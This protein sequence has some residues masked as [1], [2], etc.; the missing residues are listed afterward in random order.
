[1]QL[2]KFDCDSVLKF[3]NGDGV[4]VDVC[5]GV[6]AAVVDVTIADDAAGGDGA[7]VRAISIKYLG[8][9]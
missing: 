6:I 5:A 1:M 9:V 4:D 8:D 7:D 2:S 3:G